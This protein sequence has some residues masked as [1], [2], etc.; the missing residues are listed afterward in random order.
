MGTNFSGRTNL[1]G[2]CKTAL[3]QLVEGTAQGAGLF[4][5]SDR[6]F[7]LTQN[8]SFSQD[9]GVETAGHSEGM[10]GH[11]AFFKH[12]SVGAQLMGRDATCLR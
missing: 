1:F 9:H 8:L 12:V 10:P 11:M 5:G 6:I 3:K 2:H 4:S 7:E